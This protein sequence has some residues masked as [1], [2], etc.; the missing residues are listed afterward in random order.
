MATLDLVSAGETNW[1]TQQ[2]ANLTALNTELIATTAKANAAQ[3]AADLD[4][5][6]AALA[7]DSESALRTELNAAYASYVSIAKNPDSIISGD[8]TL[9]G[10]GLVSSAVRS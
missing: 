7:A 8:I 10:S 9:D 1:A 6:T 4:D 2:N 3:V 5:D